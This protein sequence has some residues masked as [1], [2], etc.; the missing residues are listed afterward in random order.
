MQGS[1]SSLHVKCQRAQ[2][3]VVVFL[4]FE[5]AM[6]EKP[7]APKWAAVLG[8]Q[9]VWL[10]KDKIMYQGFHTVELSPRYKAAVREERAKPSLQ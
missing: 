9:L 3:F 10:E 2:F 5:S 7:R 1:P 4:A 6:S 8:L